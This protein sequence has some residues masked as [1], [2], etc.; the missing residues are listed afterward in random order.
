M[1]IAL[2]APIEESIPPRKYGGTELIVYSLAQILP[3]KGHDVFLFATGDSKTNAKLIPIFPKAIRKEK[4]AFDA[5]NRDIMKYVAAGNLIKSLKGM[6]FDI[7]HN[8]MQ[9][10]FMPFAP[11]F[12]C[13]VL[14]TLHGPLDSIYGKLVYSRFK[15]HPYASISNA[16]RKPMPDLNYAA[17]VYNGIDLKQF[18]FKQESKKEYLAFLGRMSPEKG[19]LQAIQ[20]AKKSGMKLKMAAKIDAV[21]K[22]YFEKNVK[23]LIDQKQIE[24]IGEIGPKERNRFLRNA[25]ALLAP[26]QW[27]EP[28][29]LF[30]V[31]AMATGTPSI[32]FDRGSAREVVDNGKSGF[33]VKNVNEAVKAIDKIKGIDRKYCREWVE[34]N[35]TEEKMVEEYEKVYNKLLKK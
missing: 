9:W 5:K 8:H 14:T 34:N 18:D 29:G 26:I 23:P 32:V 12:D 16:Q 24:F 11:L 31:E 22:E 28:F 4:L 3:K 21:D 10:R 7:I 6:N 27:E 25:Y 17:T 15:N 2:I 13:P 19:P 1:K 33:V 20:I 30:I 35:F